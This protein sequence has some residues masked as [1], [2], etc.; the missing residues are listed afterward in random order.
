MFS[1]TQN[2][3]FHNSHWP[4]LLNIANVPLKPYWHLLFVKRYCLIQHHI[5]WFSIGTTTNSLPTTSSPL[6]I[7]SPP[8]LTTKSLQ[9]QEL[10]TSSLWCQKLTSKAP[11]HIPRHP[12]RV[13]EQPSMSRRDQDRSPRANPSISAISSQKHPISFQ[14]R[15]LPL[16]TFVP[17]TKPPVTYIDFLLLFD[18]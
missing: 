6:T 2:G 7:A 15:S 1:Q 16:D 11:Q 12:E 4:A 5:L 14:N 9:C 3:C 17:R 18:V 8:T 13:W 10:T